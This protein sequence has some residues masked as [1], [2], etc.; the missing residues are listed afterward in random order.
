[1][2]VNT[3]NTATSRFSRRTLLAAVLVAPA[4]TAV[5]AA[6]GDNTKGAG[7]NPPTSTGTDGTTSNTTANTTATTATTPVTI[8]TPG[9]VHP[10]GA[11][12][13]VVEISHPGGFVPEGRAFTNVADL[14]ISGDGRLFTP[15][16]T[17]AIYPGPLLPAISER[18]ITEAGI[19]KIL[20]LAEQAALLQTPPDY[21]ADLNVADAPDTRVVLAVDGRV[22]IHQ[23]YALGFQD[24]AE[25]KPRV[26]LNGFVIQMQD[27]EAVIGA[28]QL[29]PDAPIVAESYRLQARPVTPEQLA[30]YA[31]DPAPTQMPWPTTTGVTLA[32]AEN[33]ALV[34]AAAVGTLFADA[35][36]LTFFV[37][38]EVIYSVAVV[39][40]LPGTIC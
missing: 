12:D 30:S 5:L 29:G 31:P 1:M 38:N 22:Y 21:S 24:P 10:T 16:P 7:S 23:A 14:L 2:H 37:E 9:I 4:L 19:Q 26:V 27:L 32:G 36:Q 20:Q 33:C 34:S 35:N 13:V 11:D 8:S 6:C 25:S 15:G 39:A 18:T 28:G 3:S 17:L 40:V